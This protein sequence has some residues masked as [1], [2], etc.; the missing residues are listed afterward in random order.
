MA[1]SRDNVETILIRRVG[2]LLT[3]AGLDGTTINGSNPDLNDPIGY[4]LRQLDITVAD[5]T[6][7][8]DAE[9]DTT[10]AADYDK[11]FDLAE[12]RALASILG[13]IASVDMKLGPRTE[14]FGQLGRRVKDLVATKR[15]F[16]QEEY[17]FTLGQLDTGTVDLNFQEPFPT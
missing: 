11:L 17:G 14:S 13:N 12:F 4:A 10:A 3:S 9:V 15:N 5:V 16:L 6:S 2:G 1:L 7:V 8:S